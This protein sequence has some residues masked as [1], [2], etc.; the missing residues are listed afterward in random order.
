MRR[1][2]IAI[3]TILLLINGTEDPVNPCGGGRVALAGLL[4]DRGEVLSAAADR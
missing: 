3:G 1:R 2:S 4:A